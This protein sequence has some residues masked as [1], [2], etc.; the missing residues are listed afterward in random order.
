[1][2]IVRGGASTDGFADNGGPAGVLYELLIAC[3]YYGFIAASIAEVRPSPINRID[4]ESLADLLLAHLLHPLRRW[5][6]PLGLCDPRAPLWP[7]PRLLHRLPQ[8]L[9][10]DIRPRIHRLHPV[11]RSGANVRSLPPSPRH[12]T[13]ARLCRFHHHHLV[14][15]RACSVWES[16]IAT[17]ESDWIVPGYCW[18]TCNHHRSRSDAQSTCQ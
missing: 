11:Q 3:F 12:T 14:L 8:L 4:T 7:R 18:W 15:L 17:V 2:L 5:S 16:I 6:L 13:L 9:R 1:M 10:L